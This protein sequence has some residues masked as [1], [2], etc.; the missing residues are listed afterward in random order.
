MKVQIYAIYDPRNQKDV[1]YVGKTIRSLRERMYAHMF[2]ARHDKK[3]PLYLWMRKLIRQGVVPE[4][5]VIELTSE[6]DWPLREQHWIAHFRRQADSKLLNLTDGGESNLNWIPSKATRRK[7]SISNKG[8]IGYWRG[9]TMSNEHRAKIGDAQRGRKKAL[10]TRIKISKA[11]QGVKLTE[12][13]KLALSNAKQRKKKPVLKICTKT[14]VVISEYESISSALLA[15]GI[16]HLK[17]NLIGVCKGRLET[18]HG[19]KWRYKN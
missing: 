14:G 8:K 9:K 16:Q 12:Q 18:C 6:S 3:R 17:T 5:R 11:L 19:F 15:H 4:I 7:I 1:R 13:H 2:H 10:K